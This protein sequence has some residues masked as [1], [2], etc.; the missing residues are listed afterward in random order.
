ML[1]KSN[2]AS[3]YSRKQLKNIAYISCTHAMQVYSMYRARLINWPLISVKCKE[4]VNSQYIYAK[5]K[6]IICNDI[7]QDKSQYHCW[8]G[9]LRQIL[10]PLQESPMY[11]TWLWCPWR[12]TTSIQ[13]TSP[14]GRF[15]F[16]ALVI[17][18][19]KIWTSKH[20]LRYKKH[21]LGQKAASIPTDLVSQRPPR[22]HPS[23]SLCWV[24]SNPS[25]RTWKC[26]LKDS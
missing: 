2:T 6:N 7:V 8:E 9:S 23:S 20:R 5:L 26:F 21:N 18:P 13:W 3:D 25:A 14:I 1:Y 19:G 10:I 11:T 4:V 17:T 16:F 24:L 12:E 15:F 22:S